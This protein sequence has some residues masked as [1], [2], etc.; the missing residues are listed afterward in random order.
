MAGLVWRDYFPTALF[1]TGCNRADNA[2][3][4]T[5]A[6]VGTLGKLKSALL[7]RDGILLIPLAALIATSPRLILGVSCGHDFGFHL[8]SWLETQRSWSQGIA[9]PHWA[10]TPNWGAGEARFVF[11]PPITWMLGALL[12]YGIA[13]NWVP[14]TLTFLFLTAAGLT[15]RALAR[16]FL[17]APSATL[18]GAIATTTPYGLFTVYERS[19]FAELAAAAL[20]PLLL[21]LAWRQ[22]ALARGS[23]SQIRCALDG[24]AM[25]LAIVLAAVWLTNAP[26]GVMASY[27]LAFAALAAAIILRQWWPVLRAAVAAPLSLALAALYLVPAAWEQRWI[28]IQ[29]AVDVGMRIRDSW[30]FARHASPDLQLHD[31]VLRAASILAVVTVV[32]A[33]LALVLARRK[34]PHAGRYL[35]LPLALLIPILFLLQFS[36][37]EPVWNLLPKLQFLQF[38]WRWLMV[39]GTLFAIFLAAA[40]PL[41]TRRSRIW[42]AIGWAAALL[43]LTTVAS[44]TFFQICDEED[45][46]SNQVAIF[47]AGTGV[48]GTDEYAA[49]NSDNSLIASGLPDGCLVSDPAQELGESGSD[50]DSQSTPVWYPEQGSCDE[51]Y[52]AQIW[53]NEHKLFQIDS[54]HD[55]FVV[56]RLSRYPAWQITVDHRVVSQLPNREDGL[57]AVPVPAGPSTIELRWTATPDVLWGRWISSAGLFLAVCLGFCER[58]FSRTHLSS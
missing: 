31:Q 8:V 38:P 24:S 52:T 35:W 50:P 7:F 18:A 26:A 53:Q 12:G 43:V 37:T 13:W 33:A 30:L 10:Q 23:I 36:V 41:G 57:I 44:R 25:P 39:L 3:P 19:A 42:A 48:E 9:Y 45:A 28:D 49:A 21:L 16:Q 17:P 4:A 40:T 27:L 5:G 47:Q 51:T 14:A 1:A 29:Q 54:D 20:I 34:L 15:T 55:G 46:V 32:F 11:Y 58:M 2:H 6:V 56:L 22:P